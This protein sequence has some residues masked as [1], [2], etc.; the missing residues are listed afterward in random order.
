VKGLFTVCDIC[1]HGGHV[2]HMTLWFSKHIECPTGCGCN[3]ALSPLLSGA[4][5][6]STPM[7]TENDPV[8]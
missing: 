3:C 4:T 2:G 1:N 6:A 7:A 5:E 8:M